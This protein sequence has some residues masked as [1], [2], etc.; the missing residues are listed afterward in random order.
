ML[1]NDIF[2]KT[3]LESAFKVAFKPVKGVVALFTGANVEIYVLH[4]IS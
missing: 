3:A 1:S 4:H 2:F